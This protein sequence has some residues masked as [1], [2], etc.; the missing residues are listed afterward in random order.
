MLADYLSSEERERA[1]LESHRQARITLEPAE[2]NEPDQS[3]EIQAKALEFADALEDAH[4]ASLNKQSESEIA[5]AFNAAEMKREQL[6]KFSQVEKESRLSPEQK[7][8]TL[9]IYERELTR[10]EHSITRAKISQMIETGKL[11]LA[12]LETK[13]AG[14]IF[15]RKEREEIKLEAGERTRENLEPKELWAHHGDVS[16]KLQQ[17][18]LAASDALE[19]AHEIYHEPDA[20]KQEMTRA[21]SALD[22]GIVRLKEE[23]RTDRNA[24]KFIN[25]KTEFKRDLA[26]M[27][28][29]GQTLDDSRMLTA[30]TKGLLIDGL[31]KQ[32]IQPEKIGV[33]SEKLSEISR[34]ITMVMVDDKKRQKTIIAFNSK[35]VAPVQ[36]S[37]AAE[38]QTNTEKH[39]AP[40]KMRQ[41][42]HSR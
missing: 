28:G 37:R 30:M 26:Q 34:T 33:S 10:N 12:E 3:S 6:R 22:D 18:A 25:F 20:N 32:N 31:E 2:L 23:R 14:E 17:I 19:R 9:K 11:S 15:S 27:F 41:I 4:Q 5:N 8:A 40:I 42:E 29:R 1:R 38:M 7:P 35:P 13:K 21:F 24:A 16:E 39:N 36:D